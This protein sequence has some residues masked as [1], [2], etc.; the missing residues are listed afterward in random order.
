MTVSTIAFAERMRRHWEDT[1]GNVSSPSLEAIWQ[2]MADAFGQAIDAHGTKEAGHW[3][4]LQP[5]TGTG[6]SQGLA[7]YCAMLAEI[8]SRQVGDRNAR[9]VGVLIVVRLIEQA[10]EMVRTIN[11][12]AGFEAA[13]AKH[14]GVRLSPEAIE[15]AQILVVTHR[16]YEN[17]LLRTIDHGFVHS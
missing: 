10:E 7:V 8:A 13:L 16:A 1:L 14:S 2:Q 9:P 3:R 15:A 6:K 17:A 5:S 11:G 12:L 4:I